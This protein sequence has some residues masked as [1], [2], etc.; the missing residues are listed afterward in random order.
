[1][2]RFLSAANDPEWSFG[3]ANLGDCHVNP[4]TLS[5]SEGNNKD[6]SMA[7]YIGV[8]V[9]LGAGLGSAFGAAFGNVAM[10]VALGPTFGIALALALW[11]V[12]SGNGTE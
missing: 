9:A 11:S 4:G 12:R 1:M 8:G 10:G 3:C 6:E 7:L 2:V 5:M